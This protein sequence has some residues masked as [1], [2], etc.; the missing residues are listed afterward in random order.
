VKNIRKNI[1][2]ALEAG[3]W[4][5]LILMVVVL[6]MIVAALFPTITA[7][8]TSY[9]ENETIFGPV[10]AALVPLII[11]ACILIAVVV[12]LLAATK[13]KGGL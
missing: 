13:H 10:I 9:E 7:S 6:L 3:N 11:G 12:S 1:S 4:V 8:L 5:Y 2:G